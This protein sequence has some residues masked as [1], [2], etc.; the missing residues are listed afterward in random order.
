MEFMTQPARLRANVLH[1]N[2]VL[3]TV[4]GWTPQIQDRLGPALAA[5][6]AIASAHKAWTSRRKA[7]PVLPE[8]FVVETRPA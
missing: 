8:T 4:L 5:K 7:T 1:A 3:R 6:L 2:G